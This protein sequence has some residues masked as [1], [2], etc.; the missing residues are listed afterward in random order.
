M[1]YQTALFLV[2]MAMVSFSLGQAAELR[3]GRVFCDHAVLQRNTTVVIWG[4]ASPDQV[5]KVSFAG[6]T[7]EAM[8]SADGCWEVRLKPMEASMDGREL[9]VVAGEKSEA[10]RDVLVGDVWH[11]SGQSNMAMTMQSVAKRLESAVEHIRNAEH[12]GLR[13]CR[14]QGGPSKVALL[15]SGELSWARITPNSVGKVSAVAFYTARK[16]HEDL[17]IPI[18]ILDSSR[19]GTPIEPYIPVG[20]FVNHPTLVRERE[21]GEAEDLAALARLPGGVRARDAHWL[22]GRLFNSRLAPLQ[23]FAVKGALWYQ[24]ESNSGVMEDPR[25]Y[26]YKMRA[27]VTGWRASLGQAEMPFYYVQ[28]PGSGAGAGWPYLR[29]QQ[30]LSLS[31]PHTGMAVTIDLLE[32]DIHPANK[33]DVGKRLAR[34]ALANTYRREV[35]PSGPLFQRLTVDGHQAVVHFNHTD[36][37][38]RL[39]VKR[40]LA[41]PSSEDEMTLD[42]V[43]VADE[44][45]VWHPA[46]ARIDGKTLVVESE[47]VAAPVAVRYAYAVDPQHAYL[48]NAAGLP[49]SPFCSHPQWLRYDPQL[50]KE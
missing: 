19:G 16:L 24:G 3:L 17:G 35:V 15:E 38:L 20:A 28:L 45:K 22:P 9:L 8:A 27:L 46:V 49:A 13:F 10:V 34:L 33:V 30:R 12:P 42:H 2:M 48:Y 11:A 43:E 29:E 25:D 5:V 36:G 39:A 32:K 31:V 21:L 26:E 6:Q 18:G 4:W 44:T 37:G 40:G 41:P 7:V 50:P 1:P 23:R 14:I 47:R